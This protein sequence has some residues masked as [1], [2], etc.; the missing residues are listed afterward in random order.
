MYHLF[1][2]MLF[3]QWHVIPICLLM[4]IAANLE[5]SRGVTKELHPCETCVPD[6]CLQGREKLTK[7][8]KTE[9]DKKRI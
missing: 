1:E 4:D 5:E 2:K 3:V 7:G 6:V 8:W 9:W